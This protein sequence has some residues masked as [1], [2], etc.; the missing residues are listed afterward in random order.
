MRRI[1][2]QAIARFLAEPLLKLGGFERLLLGSEGLVELAGL[3]MRGGERVDEVRLLV[4]SEL[5][6]SQR[7][8]LCSLTIA[9]SVLRRRREQPRERV[10]DLGITTT[11]GQRLVEVF[12]RRLVRADRAIELPARRVRARKLR[13]RELAGDN[14]DRKSVV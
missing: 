10:V 9:Q 4:A 11:G 6:S 12:D 5:A 8:L 7:E 14:R 1:E 3:G 2:L 13:T